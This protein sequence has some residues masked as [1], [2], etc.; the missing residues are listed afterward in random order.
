MIGYRDKLLLLMGFSGVFRWFEFINL[1]VE[2]VSV[3]LEGLI[4]CIKKLKMD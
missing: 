1:D 3:M 4:V 2:D